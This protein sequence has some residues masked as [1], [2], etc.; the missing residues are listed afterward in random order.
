LDPYWITI[1]VFF[2]SFFFFISF[3]IAPYLTLRPLEKAR[4]VLFDLQLF[5][6]AYWNIVFWVYRI[7]SPSEP[8]EQPTL[9]ES[10]VVPEGSDPEGSIYMIYPQMTLIF[11]A[12][13]IIGLLLLHRT[14]RRKKKAGG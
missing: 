8:W 9:I 6:F 13:I 2:G 11:A 4:K 12:F 14:A 1:F 10:L 3:L 7:R 5:C